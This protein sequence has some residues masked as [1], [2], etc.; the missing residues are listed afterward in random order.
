MND[1]YENIEEYN[2]N[3]ER[4]ILAMFYDKINDMLSNKNLQQI[5][6]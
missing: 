2:L 4:K 3:K 1:I 5:V 6:A